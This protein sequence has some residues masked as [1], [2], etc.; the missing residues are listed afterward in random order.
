MGRPGKV[1]KDLPPAMIDFIRL[2]N[3]A[4]QELTG[5]YRSGLKLIEE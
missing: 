2:G 4:Y 5:R 3:L 1:T